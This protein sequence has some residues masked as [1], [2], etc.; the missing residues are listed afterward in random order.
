M[1]NLD[2]LSAP[3]FGRRP[4]D[5]VSA[6]A[7]VTSSEQITVPA[8]ATIVVLS[9]TLPFHVAFGSN[10]TAAVPA[11]LDDGTANELVN[12]ATPMESRSFQV[13]PGTKIAVAAATSALITASFYC[14]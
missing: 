11:D 2:V 7:A 13:T 1:Q 6:R 12:P 4:A 3:R 9:G 8:L 14:Q 5:Y 10:P